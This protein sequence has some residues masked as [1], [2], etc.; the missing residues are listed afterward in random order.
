MLRTVLAEILSPHITTLPSRSLSLGIKK[1][2]FGYPIR[3]RDPET[4]EPPNTRRRAVRDAPA[5]P[6]VPQPHSYNEHT[7]ESVSLYK[8]FLEDDRRNIRRLFVE[9][10]EKFEGEVTQVEFQ[11]GMQRT[12]LIARKH[13]ETRSF[14]RTGDIVVSTYLEIQ[15]NHVMSCEP[16]FNQNRD[17]RLSM[18]LAAFEQDS[19]EEVPLAQQK[20]FFSIGMTPKQA[21]H[22]FMITA[23]QA[24]PVNYKIDVSHFFL[25][26]Y[27]DISGLTINRG[28]Q[29]VIRRWGY[30]G[31]PKFSGGKTHRRPGSISTQGLARVLKGKK[32]PGIMGNKPHTTR[33]AQ[34][35]FANYEKRYII[36]EGPV[37]GVNGCF[38]YLSDSEHKD[39]IQGPL[40]HYPTFLG[41][42]TDLG[43]EIYDNSVIDPSERFEEVYEKRRDRQKF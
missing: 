21:T 8:E 32:M 40:L 17:E 25:G 27:L 36:V 18:K 15:D 42:R 12:G 34:I 2:I 41:D 11:E 4:E 39:P 10:N 33:N 5:P 19:I 3:P 38:L 26:Q 30:K 9:G 43:S 1:D 31:Q 13:G 37:Q 20:E 29:G 24:L 14:L 7:T 6:P 35:L 23:E 22:S 28:F 16:V